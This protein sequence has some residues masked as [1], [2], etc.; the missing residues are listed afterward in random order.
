[1]RLLERELRERATTGASGVAK[2]DSIRLVDDAWWQISRANAS[3]EQRAPYYQGSGWS[4]MPSAFERAAPGPDRTRFRAPLWPDIRVVIE[5]PSDRRGLVAWNAT[6]VD[7]G[8]ESGWL[9]PA[10]LWPARLE[11]DAFYRA[12]VRPD[13][14]GAVA[15]P[16]SVAGVPGFKPTSFDMWASPILR[17]DGQPLPVVEADDALRDHRW[18]ADA[19][20]R[21]GGTWEPIPMD[22]ARVRAW[23][24]RA[25]RVIG[26]PDGCFG[27]E[28]AWFIGSLDELRDWA[29]AHALLPLDRNIGSPVRTDDRAATRVY[30]ASRLLPLI[31]VAKSPS[32]PPSWSVERLVGRGGR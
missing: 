30:A 6:D 16:T 17:M 9:P 7:A 15:H 2:I 28:F 25:H 26:A 11:G 12:T 1:M 3:A 10:A 4:Q 29:A 13:D 24:L 18:I 14:S 21:Y 23:R 5:V 22:T 32:D 19:A 31:P 20:Q 27:P 8:A